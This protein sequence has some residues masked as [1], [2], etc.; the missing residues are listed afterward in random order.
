MQRHNLPESYR[1]FADSQAQM[2][3]NEVGFFMETFGQLT[4]SSDALLNMTGQVIEE[5]WGKHAGQVQKRFR[6]F[7][8]IMEENGVDA[9]ELTKLFDNGY[10]L[11]KYD[12]KAFDEKLNNVDL[13]LYNKTFGDNLTLEKF[14]N[15]KSKG[16]LKSYSAAQQLEVNKER[17]DRLSEFVER[18]M[19]DDYYK[20]QAEKYE[21]LGISS[22]TIK[23]LKGLSIERAILQNSVL[24]EKGRPIYT[25]FEKE[26]LDSLSQARKDSKSLVNSLGVLKTGIV[27]QTIG[28]ADLNSRHIEKG[29]L[30]Y[31]N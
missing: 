4:H 1:Q 9:K 19:N 3:K 29:G 27:E 8:K 23:F 22:D 25:E 16:G 26:K 2:M 15:L 13:D 18:R 17:Q 21:K 12:F 6:S 11:S 7:T 5:M 14:V 10:L 28:E 30:I 24:D 20:E 31:R